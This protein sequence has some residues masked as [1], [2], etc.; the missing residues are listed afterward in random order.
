MIHDVAWLQERHDWPGLNGIVMVE[1]RRDIDGEIEQETRF[2]ITSLG[3]QAVQLGAVVR[4]HWA[5]E[6]RS[7]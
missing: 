7:R 4:D 1:S 6:N 2:Y 5:I 3:L